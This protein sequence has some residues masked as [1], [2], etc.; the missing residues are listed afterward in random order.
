MQNNK[1]R[2]IITIISLITGLGAIGTY[3]YFKQ[4][5][6]YNC[7]DILQQVKSQFN[8]VETSYILH[9][10]KTYQKFGIETKVV[11]GGISVTKNNKPIH[12]EFIADA[13]NGQ[14]IDI[15]EV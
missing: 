12:Y 13:F 4:F 15:Y 1:L 6:Y 14:V 2:L 7:E 3:I 8:N 11:H 5:K 9:I 10:P